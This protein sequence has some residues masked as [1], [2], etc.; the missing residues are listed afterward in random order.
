MRQPFWGNGTPCRRA[1][2]SEPVCQVAYLYFLTCQAQGYGLSCCPLFWAISQQQVYYHS[3]SHNMS[4]PFRPQGSLKQHFRTKKLVGR[5]FPGPHLVASHF[6]LLE[7]RLAQLDQATAAVVPHQ[8]ANVCPLDCLKSTLA[9]SGEQVDGIR[10]VGDSF[11]PVLMAV[12][13]VFGTLLFSVGQATTW[14]YACS[15]EESSK[16][17]T[18]NSTEHGIWTCKGSG[19]WQNVVGLRV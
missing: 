10:L 7:E 19:F 9:P 13:E 12:E 3:K 6:L 4:G 1:L 8:A 14:L 18:R 17:L 2:E 16:L 15:Y 5:H 11:R